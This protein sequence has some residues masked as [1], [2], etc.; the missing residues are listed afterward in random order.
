MFHRCSHVV[1]CNVRYPSETH[2]KF[3]SREFAFFHN[4]LVNTL[5]LKFYTEHGSITAVLC[6]KF[7]SDW[8]AR[9]YFM[10][11][12]NISY[13]A[14]HPWLFDS[15]ELI[16]GGVFVFMIDIFIAYALFR[17]YFTYTLSREYR[18]VRNRYSRLLFTSEDRLCANLRVHEQSRNMTSQ[19]QY[20][21]I[22]RRHRSTLV[23]SQL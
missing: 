12:R 13:I 23:T 5:V 19:C 22:A 14:Q 20:L 17:K 10:D 21:D 4:I 15:K 16:Y 7:Q 11:E 6:A 3:K 9:T 18:L 2:L 1:L 8:T